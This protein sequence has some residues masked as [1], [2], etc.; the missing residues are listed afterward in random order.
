[1]YEI[2]A[3]AKIN[4]S[5]DIKFR[6]PDGYHEVDMIMQSIS[7]ADTLIFEPSEALILTCDHPLLATDQRNIAWRAVKIIQEFLG[8]DT[9]IKIH[10]QKK[11]PLAAGL[12]GGSADAAAVLIGLN[13]IWNLDLPLDQLLQLGLKLGADVPFCILQ[14]TA[15]AEGIGEKLTPLKSKILKPIYIL[16][17]DREL[18]TA[19][20]YQRYIHQDVQHRPNIE[21]VIS[22]LESGDLGQL[23]TNWG[24]VL[25]TS[26]RAECG[27]LNEIDAL[28]ERVGMRYYLMSGSG[29]TMFVLDPPRDAVA[30]LEERIPKSWFRC[31]ADMIG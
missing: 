1:M 21:R 18:S 31:F 26:A 30:E 23:T 22:A 12:A 29:P 11:I 9:G 7:L 4:L 15:R 19:R 20:V 5:L 16:T 25:E 3:P 10:I 8:I 13:R 17:P 28:F 2:S 27:Q 14:G 24:N 6:R